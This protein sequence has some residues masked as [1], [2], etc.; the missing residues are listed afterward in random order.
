MLPAPPPAPRRRCSVKIDKYIFSCRIF[1]KGLECGR[2]SSCADFHSGCLPSS[3]FRKMS[4][5]QKSWRSKYS[6]LANAS[7]FSALA[8]LLCPSPSV[9][10][11]YWF[12]QTVGDSVVLGPFAPQDRPP[13]EGD[14][15]PHGGGTPRSAQRALVRS[16]NTA[17][18]MGLMSTV[19]QSSP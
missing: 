11:C 19:L 16:L 10:A 18:S 14:V 4:K 8:C 13:E 2:V 9:S 1:Q 15:L 7:L 12:N 3:L 6:E 5:L 17:C